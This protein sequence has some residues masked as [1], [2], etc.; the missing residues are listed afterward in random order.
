MPAANKPAGVATKAAPRKSGDKVKVKN[1]SKYVLNLANGQIEPDK[2]GVA[3]VAEVY[4]LSHVLKE[5]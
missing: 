5:V 2:T 1:T 3:T 4:S